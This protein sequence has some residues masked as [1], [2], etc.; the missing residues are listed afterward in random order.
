MDKI[1]QPV[2]QSQYYVSYHF[3]SVIKDLIADSRL[4]DA[5]CLLLT[6]WIL[7]QQSVG[8]QPVRQ[9]PPPPNTESAHNFL[10]GKPKSDQLFCQQASM[11]DPQEFEKS[12]LLSH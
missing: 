11:F 1:E 12:S 10:F 9:A 2:P 7:Q 6:I 5:A 8:F 3:Q 4:T